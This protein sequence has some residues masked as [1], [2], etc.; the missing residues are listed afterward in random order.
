MLNIKGESSGIALTECTT[1]NERASDVNFISCKRFCKSVRTLNISKEFASRK[2][3][4]STNIRSVIIDNLLFDLVSSITRHKRY[5]IMKGK[6]RE[7]EK[8]KKINRVFY[9]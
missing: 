6:K 2:S 8:N 3:V 9:L 5:E 4:A 7:N 1:I